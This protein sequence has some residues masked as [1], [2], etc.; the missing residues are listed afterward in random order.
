VQRI[1]SGLFVLCV[2]LWAGALWTVGFMVAPTLFSAL[3]DRPLAGELA[4]RL[5]ALTGWV[6]LGCGAYLLIYLMVRDGW[7]A[8]RSGVLWL[9]LGMLVCTLAS[10]FG[11]QPLLASLKAEA[12]PREVMQSVLRDRFATWH[13]VSSIIYVVQSLLAMA[14]VLVAKPI[15]S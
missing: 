2:T 11:I 13:G 10:Q 8:W 9:V 1:A 14:L 15:S 3:S 5:F 6:G 7:R 4:G 12:W